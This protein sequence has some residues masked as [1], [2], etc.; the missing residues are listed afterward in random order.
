MQV[1]MFRS[2]FVWSVVL[3]MTAGAMP[4]TAA[5]PLSLPPV[6]V[7]GE[8]ED[9]PRMTVVPARTSVAGPTTAGLLKRVPG[10]NVNHNGPLSGIVQYRGMYGP[11]V[12][13]R[14]DGLP[15]A[16]G[17]PNLMDPPLHYAPMP[18]LEAVEVHRGIA[19]VSA[20]NE[21]IGGHVAAR[22]KSSAFTDGA[23][24]EFHGDISAS[25]QT[26]DDGYGLGGLLWGANRSHRVHVLGV[27]EEGDD[28]R[29][30]GSD[31][32]PTE[33]ERSAHGVG[34]GFRSGGHEFA[35]DVLRNETDDAG[36]P[37][38]PMDIRFFDTDKVSLSYER[39]VGAHRLKARLF[40]TDVDH[41]MTNF[42][43]R[44]P[45]PA[46]FRQ[47]A[48][49]SDARGF[50]VGVQ[51]AAGAGELALGVDGH[52]ADHDTDIFNPNNPAFFVNN[53]NGVERDRLGLFAEW[54][55]PAGERSGYGLGVR[56][57]RVDMDADE[58]DGTP[59]RV[60][61]GPRVLRGRFN[62]A[63]RDR[64]DHNVD[65]VA[66]FFHDLS[67][68]L[69]LDI[70]LGRKT[71]SPSYQEAYLWLPLEATA[72][73]ADRKRYVGDVGLDPEVAYE[74]DAGL[75]WRRGGAYAAPR[76]FYKRVDDY[77]QGVP[78][79]DPVVIAVSKANGD[80]RPLQFANVDAEL[81]GFDAR[82]G[83]AF[84]E[85]LAMDGVVS[86][87]RG[88]RRD[89]DDDL[90]RIA[91]LTATLALTYETAA[92]SVTTEAELVAEQDRV[93]ETNEED[94]TGGYGLLNVFGHYRLPNG[95]M[96][97]VGINNLFDK[98][99]AGH[100]NGYNRVRDSDV[101]VGERLP[102]A[103]RSLFARMNYSW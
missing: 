17:G 101:A 35:I 76:V 38:L 28:T 67:D 50:E 3:V 77:I 20:G 12:N 33:Y 59:A 29:F 23:D 32:H 39:A 89:I 15:M 85:R 44:Q 95:L 11:R 19:P 78:A 70:G 7:T 84:S 31:I 69:R 57:T 79:T 87:V 62:A 13:T 81:Y 14:V 5:E 86:Y 37:A 16:S 6:T 66:T 75:E 61:M 64:T 27:A 96:L 1:P 55:A 91:P 80:P 88:E 73:L 63:D 68:E 8:A 51:R 42:H 46:G 30:P 72:G 71:R 103:G 56:Y 45:P 53:F 48:A 90:Y 97:G 26:G 98:D 82:F 93:S 4:V 21:S 36:T 43:L 49:T 58:V 10:G 52:F 100:L 41:L 92:W 2:V 99:H 74:V 65:V 25:A 94:P 18:L 22:L 102:G 47:A 24:L 83:L 60:M 9:G 40:Y 54:E 34:Y